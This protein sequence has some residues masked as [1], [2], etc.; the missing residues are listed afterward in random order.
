M[1]L[2][3]RNPYWLVKNGYIYSYPSLQENI[4]TDVAVMGGEVLLV[5]W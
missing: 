2:T 3:T 4:K 5:P 1:E